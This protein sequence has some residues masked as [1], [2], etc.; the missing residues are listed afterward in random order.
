[1]SRQAHCQQKGEVKQEERSRR[2]DPPASNDKRG[3][4]ATEEGEKERRDEDRS[5]RMRSKRDI[6]LVCDYL[7]V[8]GPSRQR[9]TNLK[10]PDDKICTVILNRPCS[11]VSCVENVSLSL[12]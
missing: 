8:M 9:Q 1:M 2:S 5:W 11:F 6:L 3:T 4:C 10:Q 12:Y 7:P